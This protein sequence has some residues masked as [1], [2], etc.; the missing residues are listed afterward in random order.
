MFYHFVEKTALSP[1][2]I[3]FAPLSEISRLSVRIYFWMLCHSAGL[4]V[5]SSPVLPRPGYR[6]FIMKSGTASLPTGSF[7]SGATWALPCSLHFH[8]NFAI[9]LLVPTKKPAGVFIE[10]PSNLYM[11]LERIDLAI[12]SLLTH[13]ECITTT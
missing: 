8:R 7:F 10:V 9:S 3:A 4:F 12:L 6:G 11:N 13:V 2:G 1:L 5:C